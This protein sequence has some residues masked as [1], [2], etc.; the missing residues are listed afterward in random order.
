M[1]RMLP[2]AIVVAMAVQA[3]VAG[4]R[5]HIGIYSDESGYSCLVASGFNQNVI[6]IHKLYFESSV[7]A[8]FKM[9]LP[10]GSTF[11]TF[12]TSFNATGALTSDLSLGYGQCL[13]GSVVLG[14]VVAVLAEG[15]MEIV[16]ADLQATIIAVDCTFAEFEASGGPA[17]AGTCCDPCIGATEA[18]TWGKVK[19]LYR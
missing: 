17:Y 14:N 2:W 5:S 7:G 3:P 4:A 16:A 18:T 15:P 12:Q 8:R 1:K 13:T 10:S 9:T 11:F 19:S 6:V